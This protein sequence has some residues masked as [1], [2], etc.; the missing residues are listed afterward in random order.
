[1][2]D[3]VFV[4]TNILIYLYSVDEPEKRQAAEKAIIGKDCVISVQVLNEFS[5]VCLRKLNIPVQQI[6]AAIDEITLRM[7]VFIINADTVRQALLL[8]SYYH[9]SYY[10][11]VILAAAMQSGCETLY[12]ED[13]SDG[14][15]IE[16]CL[17]IRNVLREKTA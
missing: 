1:M 8:S 16:K 9:Y 13:M 15:V 2:K 6:L 17:T 3:K 14:Q 11:G 5:S 7:S 4:D 10:D 12:S